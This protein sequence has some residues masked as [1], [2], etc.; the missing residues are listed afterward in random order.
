MTTARLTD[1]ESEDLTL[2][3]AVIKFGAPCVFHHVFLC[4]RHREFVCSGLRD[5][6]VHIKHS[7]C[8]DF[9]RLFLFLKSY[10]QFK[11]QFCI[12]LCVLKLKCACAHTGT[13][14]FELHK[15]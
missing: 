3:L 14:V 15:D 13:F 9:M 8:A 11:E 2:L 4:A 12:L 5:G 10:T 1:E 6:L 7:L